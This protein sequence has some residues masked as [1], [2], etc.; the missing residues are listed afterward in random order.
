M[1]KI[2]LETTS[3]K[4]IHFPVL[5][6]DVNSPDDAMKIP[7]SVVRDRNRCF[8]GIIQITDPT[9]GS[10]TFDFSMVGRTGECNQ[11][12]QCCTHPV[13]ACPDVGGACGWPYRA[14]I[15]AHACQHLVVKNLSKWGQ[16]K[17]SSCGIYETL[18]DTYKGCIYPL[19]SPDE[20]LPHMT[21][22]GFE[23]I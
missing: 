5:E 22:C 7:T 19:T 1:G 18:I 20:L 2:W 13:G 14:D 4:L 17:N 9:Y 11:C 3:G 23:F 12:G 21:A 15:D 8:S 6:G 16:T 10:I